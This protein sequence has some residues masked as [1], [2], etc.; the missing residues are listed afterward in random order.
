[1]T[2]GWLPQSYCCS[3]ALGFH[4]TA[5]PP[6]FP[7]RKSVETP[8]VN[9]W[10]C[11]GRA[12]RFPPGTSAKTR[13]ISSSIPWPWQTLSAR[14]FATGTSIL[15]FGHVIGFGGSGEIFLHHGAGGEGKERRS[16]GGGMKTGALAVTSLGR[17]AAILNTRICHAEFRVWQ[18]RGGDEAKQSRWLRRV[19]EGKSR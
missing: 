3:R 18:E 8:A 13:A 14:P 11:E 10:P 19:I 5:P 16:R 6:I 2:R 4:A 1:M 17:F 9:G 12:T 15:P 7:I